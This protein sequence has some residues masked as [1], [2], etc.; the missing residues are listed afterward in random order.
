M[1]MLS[2]LFLFLFFCD[3]DA[4]LSLFFFMG[5]EEY[6]VS[7]ISGQVLSLDPSGP[8]AVSA[9]PRENPYPEMSQ[10]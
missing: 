7:G 3:K 10:L 6:C 9:G 2:L 1:F 5:W 4:A 8:N